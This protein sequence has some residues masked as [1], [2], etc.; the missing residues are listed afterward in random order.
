VKHW[1]NYVTCKVLK[2]IGVKLYNQLNNYQREEGG[3]GGVE[4]EFKIFWRD[5]TGEFLTS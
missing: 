3:H 5:N 1:E 4:L 2:L